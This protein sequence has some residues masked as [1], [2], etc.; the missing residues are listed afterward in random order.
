MQAAA[1]IWRNRSLRTCVMLFLIV[2][3][4]AGCATQPIPRAYD[5]PGLFS[6]IFHGAT[7][8]PALFVSMLT[9]VRIYAFPN[10]GFFYD[11]GFVF[12]LFIQ[13]IFLI[14]ALSR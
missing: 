10:S 11:L 3:F 8:L 14:V 2:V 5:P 7:V 12:G 4:V 13:L 6:G 1:A 9:D